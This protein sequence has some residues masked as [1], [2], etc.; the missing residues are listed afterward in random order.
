MTILRGRL[1]KSGIVVVGLNLNFFIF[2]A[3]KGIH[4]QVTKWV[5]VCENSLKSEAHGDLSFGCPA[6][7]EGLVQGV[8]WG[9][10]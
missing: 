3:M 8:I 10:L 2:C 9:Q 7:L 1:Y 6:T 5:L 4:A